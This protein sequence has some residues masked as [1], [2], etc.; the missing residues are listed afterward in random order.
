MANEN[1]IGGKWVP[2]A[3]GLTDPVI[4]PATGETIAEVPS[5]DS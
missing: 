3:S 1:F 5:S 4:D 2:A